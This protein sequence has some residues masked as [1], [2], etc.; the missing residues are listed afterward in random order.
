MFTETK[1]QEFVHA[2]EEGG[3]VPVVR[4]LLILALTCG[5][6]VLFLIFDFKGLSHSK[7]MEQAQI[8]RELSRGH[9]F[10]T[11]FIRPAA[12]AQFDANK[13]AVPRDA[14]PDTYHAPLNPLINAPFLW[15]AKSKLGMTSKDIV[16][17][18]DRIVA[19][20][21]VLCFILGVGV[22]YLT[23]RRLFDGR[24]AAVSSGVVLLSLK[25]WQFAVSGLPQMLMFLLF[26]LCVYCLLRA[27][28]ARSDE[29]APL[30]WIFLAAIGFSL[31]ALAHGLTI[32]IFVAAVVFVA[33]YFPKRLLNL[34]I[35]LGIFIVVYAPWLIRNYKVCGN[36]A[37]VAGYAAFYQVRGQESEIMRAMPFKPGGFS[38]LHFRSKVQNQILAQFASIYASF[39]SVLL[40]P[41][42]FVAL[43]HL[44]RS[45]TASQFRWC[46][47][48]LWLGALFGMS[49]FGFPDRETLQSNDLHLLFVPFFAAY[50]AAFLLSL[51]NRLEL[52]IPFLRLSFIT[53]LLLISGAPLLNQL[54]SSDNTRVQW[55]PYVPP[56][57]AILSEWTNAGEMIMSDMPWAVAWYADRKSLWL[58]LNISDYVALNDYNLLNSNI[59]GMYLTPVTGNS[60]FVSDIT[61]GEWKDW[62]SFIKREVSSSD[63]PL[64]AS[65]ALPINYEC[66][67]YADRDRWSTKVD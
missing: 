43:L 30:L 59:A 67:F 42:F 51:F 32:W 63:F 28:Q 45:N 50:G 57:I 19:T 39:G 21:A 60:A 7:G 4:L 17:I 29:G 46:L 6:A 5:V 55:P 20:V 53:F 31:L 22:S 54:T 12:L 1:V 49:L 9:G 10:S 47:L 15:L 13:V 23:V 38:P 33:I 44:F 40:A 41:V 34:G 27:V 48:L 14:I 25:Y 3:W 11:K 8:A 65:T 66:I 35:M 26:S 2:I 64:K 36:P 56:Y 24:I 18:G 61:K 37:G 16:Y 62:A 52:K 58:P